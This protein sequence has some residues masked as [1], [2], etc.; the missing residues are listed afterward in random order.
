MTIPSTKIE[1]P[2]GGEYDSAFLRQW[3]MPADEEGVGVALPRHADRS[4]QISG[5][6]DGATLKIEGTID[7]TTWGILTD[8][9]GNDLS[10]T[11]YPAGYSTKIEAISEATVALRPKTV[12]GGASTALVITLLSRS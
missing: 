11:S 7:G 2:P 10:F 5:P 12:G 1:T 3:T 8:P 6:F 9:Q 4:I